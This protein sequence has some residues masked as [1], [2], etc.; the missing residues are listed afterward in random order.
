MASKTVPIS[1]DLVGC[2]VSQ[3]LQQ[4]NDLEFGEVVI[5]ISVTDGVF[6]VGRTEIERVFSPGT[7]LQLM[8]EASDEK[9]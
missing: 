3:A 8:C 1:K 5:R 9:P 7:V 6:R 4:A 2:L